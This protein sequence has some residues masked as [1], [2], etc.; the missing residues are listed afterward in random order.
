VRLVTKCAPE[1]REGVADP[2]G[3]RPLT[4]TEDARGEQA[5][6]ARPADGD[7]RDR[8]PRR[9]LHDGQQGIHAVE[10]LQRHGHPDD[11]ERG[12]RRQHARQVGRSPGSGDDD[13]QTA[14]LRAG[15]V[16]HHLLRHPVRRDDVDLAG[17]AELVEG[18]G[19]RLH[20]RPVRVRPHDDADHGHLT[21][22]LGALFLSA[23]SVTTPWM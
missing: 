20:D 5:G 12:D 19:R 11:R 3:L 6:V 13:A 15:A 9:H 1:G 23:H 7:G 4:G 16:P 10:V 21:G 8:H 2:R 18:S 22:D 17:D 14:L